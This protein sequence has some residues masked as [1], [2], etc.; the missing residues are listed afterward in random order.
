[1]RWINQESCIINGEITTNYFEWNSGTRQGD[2]IS[3]YLFI[4]LLPVVFVMIKS[5]QNIGKLRIFEHDL[6]YTAYTNT[7][8]AVKQQTSV[9][10][11]LVFDNFS[12][13]S[14][15]EPN[16]SKCEIA[17]IG[18]LKEIT[19]VPDGMQ[20]INLNEQTV[21][22]LTIHFSPIKTL[23]KENNLIII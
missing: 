22:I 1:M 10:W 15:R 4:L 7:T 18:A 6:L 19:V 8:F 9:I 16:K 23:K 3:A 5:N 14:G 17:G 21:K 12:K 2:P 11:I 20:C 13:I